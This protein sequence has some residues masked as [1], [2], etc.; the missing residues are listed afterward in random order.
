M[1]NNKSLVA[2]IP[3]ESYDNEKVYEAISKGIELIGGIDSLINNNERILVKPNLLSSSNPDKAIT[4]NPSVFGSILRYLKENGYQNIT[5]GDSPAGITNMEEVVKVTGLKQ[6]ADQY[7][8]QLGDF[9]NYQT[10]DYPSGNV[11]KKFALCKGVIDADAIISISK[12]KTHAL[13]IITGAVKNQYG[14]IYSNRKSLGHAKYPNSNVF[15]KMLIDLNLYLKPRLYIMDGIIAMEGNGPA[16]GDP[17]FMKT[18][19]ISKDPI[20]LDSVFARLI[21][22]N[23]EYV[24]TIVYGD[25]YKLGTMDFDKITIIT[26]DGIKTIDEVFNKYGNKDFVVN[27]NKRSFWNLKELLHRTKKKTHKPVVDLNLCIAC[28]KCE[29]V[30][31]VNGKAV[32]SGKGNKAKYDYDKCIRCYCCQ[33]I[34]PAKAISRKDD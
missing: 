25:K 24:P 8:V 16:S 13:E 23:P 4:T 11:A 15:A 33:E 29:G 10:V 31:P 14:C 1:P 6:K 2:L 21:D 32:H 3:C 7:N 18:I 12:M 9:D 27:R 26:P 34:C 28:G 19:L 30:C 17:V 5:Y 22:L 20:A